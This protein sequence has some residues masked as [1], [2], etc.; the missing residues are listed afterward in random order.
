MFK[1]FDGRD[2]FWQW[3][4]NQQLI[5]DTDKACLVHFCNK[6][7]E[8]A[9]VCKPYD[10]EGHRVVDVPNIFLQT[11]RPITAFIY[12]KNGDESHTDY[13]A[14]FMVRPRTKPSDYVYE[15][16][17]VLTYED[18]Y[19]RIE[20]IESKIGGGSYYDSYTREEIDAM[21]AEVNNAFEE[22]NKSLEEVNVRTYK[23]L[24]EFDNSRRDMYYMQYEAECVPMDENYFILTSNGDVSRAD[25]WDD[26]I[27][28][29]CIPSVI[30]LSLVRSIAASAFRLYR[31]LQKLYLPKGLTSIKESAFYEC[32]G[33]SYVKFSDSITDIGPRAFSGCGFLTDLVLPKSL[34]T[35]GAYAFSGLSNLITLEIPD[36]VTSID[37]AAF[38]R[39]ERLTS[40]TIPSSVLAIGNQVFDKCNNLV[41]I[42]FHGSESQWNSLIADTTST[43][44]EGVKVVFLGTAAT[45]AYVE[46]ISNNKA[47]RVTINTS[48]D[49]EYVYDFNAEYNKEV[50]LSN[51][52]TISFYPEANIDKEDYVSSLSFL[53]VD[54]APYVDYPAASGAINWIG[55]DCVYD[56]GTS[57]FIPVAN[58]QYDIVF[59]HNGK[60]IVGM[61]NGYT[62]A[63]SNEV[64]P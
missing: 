38:T 41:E 59:Y 57:V 10:K 18:L 4:L 49:S 35:I 53:T 12:I 50:R 46:N 14:T 61:V 17:E 39:C 44:P 60:S 21:V 47:D 54:T 62:L 1:I 5:I 63:T 45:E 7:T 3:D 52:K 43:V 28:D 16:T 37:T 6:T 20:D 8:C 56:N 26:S 11:S 64:S 40:V 48:D 36:G 24:N 22:A 27:T 32:S 15:E 33:L 34:K 51:P 29:V 30:S 55:T 31:P 19:R 13:T 9:L 42:T 23:I 2:S 58:K 25:N